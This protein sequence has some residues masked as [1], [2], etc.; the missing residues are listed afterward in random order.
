MKKDIIDIAKVNGTEVVLDAQICRHMYNKKSTL[1][2]TSNKVCCSRCGY[3]F[4]EE[5]AH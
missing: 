2:K 1:I 4:V 3:S 5:G